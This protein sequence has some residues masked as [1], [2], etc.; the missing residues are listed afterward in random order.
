MCLKYTSVYKNIDISSFLIEV[1]LF[2]CS[3]DKKF[4]KKLVSSKIFVYFK[5]DS[6]FEREIKRV[7]NLNF[8]KKESKKFTK[9]I[10]N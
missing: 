9:P 6:L 4:I 5:V 3:K 7:S 10:I 1:E 8:F 2:K